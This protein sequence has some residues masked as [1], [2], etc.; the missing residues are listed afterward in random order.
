MLLAFGAPR[1]IGPLAGLEHGRTASRPAAAL[2]AG[3][4]YL[5][6]KTGSA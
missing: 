2:Q 4:T 6:Q 1:Q 3:V 5:T